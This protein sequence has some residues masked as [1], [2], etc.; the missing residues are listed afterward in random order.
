MAAIFSPVRSSQQIP[1]AG[2]GP[3]RRQSITR[4]GVTMKSSGTSWPVTGI[5]P[6]AQTW[7][8]CTVVTQTVCGP[9]RPAAVASANSRSANPPP[10]PRRAPSSPAATQPITTRSTA[11]SSSSLTRR[12]DRVAPLIEAALRGGSLSRAGSS[13][14]NGSGSASRGTAM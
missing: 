3:P 13:A 12:A 9:I 14:K 7:S 10:L 5:V 8:S 4:S 2:R 11:D 1:A 6:A